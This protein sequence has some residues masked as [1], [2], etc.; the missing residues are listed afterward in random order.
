[1]GYSIAIRVS[2]VKKRAK[3]LAFM[4]NNYCRWNLVWGKGESISAGNITTD[5]DYDTSAK[6]ALGFNYKSHL[7][8][9]E[10]VYVYD[11]L[12][13]MALKV[14]N[15]KSRFKDGADKPFVSPTPLPYVVY[16]GCDV[17]PVLSC[18]SETTIKKLPGAKTWSVVDQFGVEYPS[19]SLTYACTPTKALLEALSK[20]PRPKKSSG[21]SWEAWS[22][23]WQA[24]MFKFMLPEMKRMN[25]VIRKELMRLDQLWLETTD[26]G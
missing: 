1:M 8:G 15:R 7:R 2:S 26:S 22:R 5:L 17:W 9:W 24:T 12:F 21:P 23:K 3:M 20:I 25:S 18:A 19:T 14:G 4:A 13:W 11:V 6:T 16:D 10:R